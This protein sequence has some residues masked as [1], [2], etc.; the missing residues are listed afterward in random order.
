MRSG[1]PCEAINHYRI[2]GGHAPRYLG[3]PDGKT[4]SRAG[5]GILEAP[6]A[7][8]VTSNKR[9]VVDATRDVRSP[10][11]P[12]WLFDPQGIA[13]EPADVGEQTF[14]A[15]PRGAVARGWSPCRPPWR[16]VR[17]WSPTRETTLMSTPILKLSTSVRWIR[18][19]PSRM[20][21]G[22]GM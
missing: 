3:A 21:T 4:T 11:G 2:L 16:T 14:R 12:A 5:P 17:C 1:G 9:D 6:G 8:L 10:P 18:Q 19:S 13:S 7:V 20:E 15:V 22:H